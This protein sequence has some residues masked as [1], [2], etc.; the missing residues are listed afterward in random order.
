M[1]KRVS[2]ASML[3]RIFIIIV[4]VLIAAAALAA[5]FVFFWPYLE[6][7]GSA[8]VEGSADWMRD[9]PDDRP[10]SLISVPGS[11]NSGAACAQLAY[12]TKCQSAGIYGQLEMGVRYLD[13]R[14]G[15]LNG[16]LTL[17]HSFCQ[18]QVSAWPLSAPLTMEAVIGDCRRFLSAHPS[19]TVILVCKSERGDDISD[20]QEMLDS[21]IGDDPMWLF[22]DSVPLMGECRGKTVLMRRWNDDAGLGDR[23]GIYVG[24]SDQGNRDDTYLMSEYEYG[25]DVG[26]YI[27]DRY[28]YD[29]EDKWDAVLDS[30]SCTPDEET[31]NICFLSTNGDNDYGHPYKYAHE[32]NRRFADSDIHTDGAW[33][34]ADFVTPALC[35]KIYS[36][37][38]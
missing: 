8:P 33:V 9:I 19:E 22:A 4:I 14:L 25:D 31:L 13:I 23:A 5:A 21:L 24:W 32:L 28:K 29:T 37:N 11:H 15:I 7:D 16:E 34:I 20:I 30:L 38:R 1:E 2:P 12:F 18:C 35:E 3:L 26:F 36:L 10:I 17:W 27:Q 6:R